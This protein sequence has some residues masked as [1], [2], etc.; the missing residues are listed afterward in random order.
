MVLTCFLKRVQDQLRKLRSAAE[1]LGIQLRNS[2]FPDLTKDYVVRSFN[3]YEKVRRGF[4]IDCIPSFSCL[5]IATIP[6]TSAH[7][8]RNQGCRGE[9]CPFNLTA[10]VFRP[11]CLWRSLGCVVSLSLCAMT[12]QPA[13]AGRELYARAMTSLQPARTRNG[14][15]RIAADPSDNP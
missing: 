4:P 5:Y 3:S 10:S 15:I 1:F 8:L 12:S 7:S 9:C 2:P 13:C 14:Q 11:Q 6:G